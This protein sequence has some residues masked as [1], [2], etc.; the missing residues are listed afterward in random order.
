MILISVSLKLMIIAGVMFS[1]GW[2]ILKD[3]GL[4]Q[5]VNWTDPCSLTLVNLERIITRP[6]PISG[7]KSPLLYFCQQGNELVTEKCDTMLDDGKQ[8]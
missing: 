2:L 3:S 6:V 8:T 5:G 1:Y 7:L 4:V